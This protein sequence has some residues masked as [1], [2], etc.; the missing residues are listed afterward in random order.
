[1]QHIALMFAKHRSF[2]LHLHNMYSVQKNKQ[3]TV[4]CLTLEFFLIHNDA[5]LHLIFCKNLP[6]T[7]KDFDAVTFDMTHI[8]K[9]QKISKLNSQAL[10]DSCLVDTM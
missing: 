2:S 4:V 1:M 9:S 8:K 5:Y 3:L 6:S 7:S 10:K